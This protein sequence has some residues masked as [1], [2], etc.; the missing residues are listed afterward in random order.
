MAHLNNEGYHMTGYIVTHRAIAEKALGKPLPPEAIIH[1]IDE[2]KSNPANNNLVIC[3]SREY[4]DLLHR[5]M[6]ALKISGNPNY[7]KCPYCK[8]WD[9]PKNMKLRFAKS[10]EYEHRE[11]QLKHQRERY[12]RQFK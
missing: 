11:C 2:D 10:K 5:R 12:A 6:E 4:H 9:D 1:H 7:R 3:P 8:Q